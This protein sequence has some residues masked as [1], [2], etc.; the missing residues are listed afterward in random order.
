MND[1]LNPTWPL[2]DG[3]VSSA[4]SLGDDE[5]NAPDDE[6]VRS[7]T[8]CCGVPEGATDPQV[9]SL[10]RTPTAESEFQLMQLICSNFKI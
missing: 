9:P 5:S 2:N 8:P 3:D 6:S 7:Y 4:A 10:H 1:N